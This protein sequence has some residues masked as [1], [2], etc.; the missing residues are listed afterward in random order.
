MKTPFQLEIPKRNVL[1]SNKGERLEPGMDIYSA[2]LEN[3]GQKFFRKDFCFSCWN[4]LQACEKGRLE[5][6]VFWRSKIEPKK[7]VENLNRTGKALFLLRDFLNHPNGKEE[8]IFVLSIFL[9][10]A[11]QLALRQEFQKEGID[12]HLYEILRQDEFLTVRAFILSDSQIETIQK[13]LA[14]QL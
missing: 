5:T 12:Y 9:S 2:L 14:S 6:K 7:T 3:E 11:R 1:C 10:H 4:S 13:S 8:E